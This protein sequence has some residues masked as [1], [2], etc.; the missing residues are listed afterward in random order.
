MLNH[1]GNLDT[2]TVPYDDLSDPVGVFV[3]FVVGFEESEM[4]QR[5]RLSKVATCAAVWVLQLTEQL[6]VR[7][8]APVFWELRFNSSPHC[9]ELQLVPHVITMRVHIR[10]AEAADPFTRNSVQVA[11]FAVMGYEYRTSRI[12]A[13]REVKAKSRWI[14]WKI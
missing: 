10:T 4:P 9:A 11:K 13:V 7:R 2:A 6:C 8:N 1:S 3:V 5:P 12:M 14:R